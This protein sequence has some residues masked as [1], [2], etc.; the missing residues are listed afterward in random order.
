MD[1]VLRVTAGPLQG[2]VYVLGDRTRIGR[3]SDVHIQLTEVGVSRQHARIVRLP[4]GA[5]ELTDLS[6]KTGTFVNGGE[7]VKH[8]LELGQA[9]TIGGSTFLFEENR[10]P[11]MTSP[12]FGQKVRGFT[13]LRATQDVPAQRGGRRA[14][15][16]PSPEPAPY[17][18]AYSQEP[19]VGVV[20][21]RVEAQPA[22][23]SRKRPS[24]VRQMP[25]V[26]AATAWSP[27]VER[28]RDE[29][30]GARLLESILRG[31]DKASA[32]EEG[33]A[34]VDTGSKGIP[35]GPVEAE[36]VPSGAA[37][38]PAAF[39]P[40]GFSTKDSG[41]MPAASP[42]AVDVPSAAP[43]PEPA[44]A[45]APKP[46]AAV[47]APEPQAPWQA[48]SVSPEAATRPEPAPRRA[49]PKPSKHVIVDAFAGLEPGSREY[50]LAVLRDVLDYRRLRLADLR[51]DVLAR[52]ERARFGDLQ[53]RLLGTTDGDD[54]P[55]TR[56]FTRFEC[57]LPA[58]VTQRDGTFSRTLDVELLDLSAGGTRLSLN[59]PAIRPGDEVWLAFNL[60]ALFSYG[61]QVVFRCRVVWTLADRGSMGLMFGGNA[62]FA[63]SVDAA[64]QGL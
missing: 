44:L 49:A 61:Q 32:P 16:P 64:L 36:S 3:A 24:T 10:A 28:N 11:A 29:G 62:V 1:R 46:P 50:A 42:V 14:S 19:G 7:V 26:G 52:A 60:A 6:S 37:N 63:P 45:R 51:G 58:T 23:A 9:L 43:K 34:N 27:A 22:S 25:A 30:S 18:A 38:S 40:V 4:D 12:T 41:P 56:R 15:A 55:S 59:D 53:A 39:E 8:R 33:A 54:L 17:A 2:S 35:L 20:A 57:R 48:P 13:A 47:L 31:S 21:A 5:Y